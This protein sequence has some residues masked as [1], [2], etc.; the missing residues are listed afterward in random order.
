M[1]A[2]QLKWHPCYGNN[3]SDLWIR[4]VEW[5]RR[6]LFANEEWLSKFL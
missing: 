4:F 2:S 1:Q 6:V 5:Y 3:C